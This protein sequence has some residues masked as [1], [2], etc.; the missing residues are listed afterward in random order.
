MGSPAVL[1]G[2][3]DDDTTLANEVRSRG[4]VLVHGGKAK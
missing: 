4:I 3:E 1:E 2:H